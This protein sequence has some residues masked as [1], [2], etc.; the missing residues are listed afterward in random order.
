MASQR[1]WY[2]TCGK[3]HTLCFSGRDSLFVNVISM[4][5]ADETLTPHHFESSPFSQAGVYYPPVSSTFWRGERVQPCGYRMYGML[6]SKS[7]TSHLTLSPPLL[8]ASRRNGSSLSIQSLS[9]SPTPHRILRNHHSSLTIND[10]S[11]A[12]Q[13][14]KRR[15]S[16]TS[17]EQQ[18]TS[19]QALNRADD[20]DV[21]SLSMDQ[22]ASPA[23]VHD[24]LSAVL[25][26]IQYWH[27]LCM[28]GSLFR[29]DSHMWVMQDWDTQG[30]VLKVFFPFAFLSFHFSYCVQIRLVHMFM[31]FASLVTIITMA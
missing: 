28:T 5:L 8:M 4:N 7:Q 25:P 30:E 9:S 1:D 11:P 13:Q 31:L 22:Q 2:R 12:Q 23:A 15:R 14:K 18:S 6:N 27:A 20:H 10:I 17:T 24:P 26:S 16:S 21:V 3:Q 29:L 19:H